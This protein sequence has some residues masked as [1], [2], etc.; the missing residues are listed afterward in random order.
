MDDV[1]L[2]RPSVER[3]NQ[4]I[5]QTTFVKF[6]PAQRQAIERIAEAEGRSISNAVRQMVREALRARGVA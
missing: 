2:G 6:T 1:Q 4:P 5:N 3:E